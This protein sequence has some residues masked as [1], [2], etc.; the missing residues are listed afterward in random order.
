[1]IRFFGL[2]LVFLAFVGTGYGMAKG[3]EEQ[4]K[5]ARE[6]L[7]LV[8]R[9]G[10]EIRC[11]KRPLPEIYSDFESEQLDGFLQIL[12]QECATKAFDALQTNPDVTRACLPFFERMGKC[13]SEECELLER[14]CDKRLT[15]LIAEM[16]E[17]AAEKTKV[18][19]SLGWASGAVAVILL[20]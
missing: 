13:S 18:Y 11:Y 8:R 7:E 3:V 15:E 2:G 20:I 12:C 19:R 14:E 16:T 4:L 6:L 10:S 1:M 5:T 17:K 9:I